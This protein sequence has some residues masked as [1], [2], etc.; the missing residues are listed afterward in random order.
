M[1][2]AVYKPKISNTALTVATHFGPPCMCKLHGRRVPV[3]ES[4]GVRQTGR[5]PGGERGGDG[6]H[7]ARGQQ[8]G[9]ETHQ[10]V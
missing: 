10:E 4:E 8:A 6:A 7:A 2:C 3:R 5:Q 1:E 9:Q